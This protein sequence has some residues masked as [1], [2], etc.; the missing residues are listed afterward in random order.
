MSEKTH[1]RKIVHTDY[2]S[3]DEIVDK[4]G[5][6]SEYTV[7]IK[8]VTEKEVV[9]PLNGQK[10]LKGIVL[11]EGTKKGMILNVTNGKMISKVVGSPMTSEWVG[12]KI[13]IYGKEDKRHGRVLRVKMQKVQ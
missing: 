5:N 6:P 12:K 13:I 3:G 2:L 8:Q 1:W 7:T 9:D 10:N 11:F 4:D